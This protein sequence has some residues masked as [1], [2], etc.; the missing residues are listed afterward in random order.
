MDIEDEG[1]IVVAQAGEAESA[2][3]VAP[4]PPAPL[5]A[6]PP[7]PPPSEDAPDVPEGRSSDRRQVHPKTCRWGTALC[8]YRAVGVTAAGRLTNPAWQIT[9]NIVQHNIGVRCTR[10]I[11]FPD[12]ELDEEISL[13]LGRHWAN[14]GVNKKSKQEHSD[15]RP[16]RDDIPDEAH[17]EAH[18]VTVKEIQVEDITPAS[19]GSGEAPAASASDAGTNGEGPDAAS[20]SC[21]RSSDDASA[22]SDSSSDS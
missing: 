11:T 22:N 2:G 12:T 1:G 5:L 13:W 16:R 9:C 7:A 4:P 21:S 8:T 17:I 19:P 6:L 18:K 15:Y 10:T 3:V 20:D 14:E